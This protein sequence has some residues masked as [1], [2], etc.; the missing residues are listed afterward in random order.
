MGTYNRM[1]DYRGSALFQG[2]QQRERKKEISNLIQ[3]D[4]TY[5]LEF[6]DLIINGMNALN[7][8]TSPSLFPSPLEGEGWG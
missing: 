3:M 2:L 1:K 4:D 7:Q 8:M 6:H 5:F